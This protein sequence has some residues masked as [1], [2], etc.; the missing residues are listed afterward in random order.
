MSVLF[1]GVL[2]GGEEVS[3]GCACEV[4]GGW[5][6][7]GVEGE[8]YQGSGGG[9]GGDKEEEGGGGEGGREGTGEV[10]GRE[11]RERRK[12]DGERWRWVW[13]RCEE[14]EGEGSYALRGMRSLVGGRGRFAMRIYVC[15]QRLWKLQCRQARRKVPNQAKNTKIGS[16]YS[17]VAST[18]SASYHRLARIIRIEVLDGNRR[19]YR[20]CRHPSSPFWGKKMS[21]CRRDLYH[22]SV[23]QIP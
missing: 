9:G 17:S 5:G 4:E 3:G 11:G 7:G 8:G 18:I 23:L 19:V 20:G 1:G 13:R 14:A 10:W 22:A 15:R 12:M 21:I 16:R 2:S 6:F